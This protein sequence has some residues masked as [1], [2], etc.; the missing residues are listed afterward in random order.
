MEDVLNQMPQI[1]T[2]NTS[3]EPSGETG[4]A[5]LDL[6]GLG[7]A[8]TLTLINGRRMQ[9]GSIWS[10]DADIGQNINVGASAQFEEILVDD[11]FSKENIMDLAAKHGFKIK[12]IKPMVFD[13][14]YVSMLSEKY[15]GG[16]FFNAIINGFISNLKA[17]RNINNSSLIYILSKNPK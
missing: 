13:S 12:A 10:E 4:T 1:E 6:R 8:R 9:P 15:K 3:F 7:G 2:A 14:Y 16:T 5:S 11:N 17:F